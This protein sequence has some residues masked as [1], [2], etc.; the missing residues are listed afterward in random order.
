MFEHAFLDLPENLP[1]KTINGKRHYHVDGEYYPSVTTALS[2]KEEGEALKKW[3]ERLGPEKAAA[4]MKRSA[5][6]GERLHSM[7]EAY[8]KNE[9]IEYPKYLPSTVEL[10]MQ[11]QP[12]LDANLGQIYAI[13][14]P[15][16]SK[17]LGVAGRVDM[18]ADWKGKPA[19]IDFKGS[20]RPKKHEWIHGYFMQESLYGYMTFEM[21]NLF[22]PK[23]ITLVATPL[24]D[25]AQVFEER[26]GEWLPKAIELVEKFYEIA[27]RSPQEAIK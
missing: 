16:Y 18:I 2:V 25:K 11:I 26:T 15:L 12:E 8:V 9:P 20:D 13:E 3:K 21:R 7:L 1:T 24:L 4:H 22:I 5:E 27:A 19:V 17:K 6:R 14:R 23:I 10:F